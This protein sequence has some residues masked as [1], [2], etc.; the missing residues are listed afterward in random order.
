MMSGR[1]SGEKRRHDSSA[2]LRSGTRMNA[3][4]SGKRARIS[5]FKTRRKLRAL[6]Q[7][8]A[9]RSHGRVEKKQDRERDTVLYSFDLFVEFFA[10]PDR[11]MPRPRSIG[12][13]ASCTLRYLHESPAS[14]NMCCYACGLHASFARYTLL[15]ACNKLFISCMMC[16]EFYG[17]RNAYFDI[18]M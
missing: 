9:L 5:C 3:I 14:M 7:S 11:T 18:F 6:L 16:C 15:H 17:T 2:Q 12:D 8:R 10:N 4:L 13:A 1:I